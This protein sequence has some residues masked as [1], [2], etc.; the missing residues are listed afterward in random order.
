MSER[1]RV[2][3]IL[4][5]CWI[6][7]GCAPKPNTEAVLIGHIAPSTGPERGAGEHARQAIM[8]ALEEAIAQGADDA[9]RIAAIHAI[10][11]GDKEGG[12][13]AVRL[14]TINRVVA[15][16]ANGELPLT[17]AVAAVAQS[18]GEPILTEEGLPARSAGT[19]VFHLGL[20]P[21]FQAQIMARHAV[22]ELKASKVA[23][24]I[25]DEG[26]RPPAE[27]ALSRELAALFVGE[28]RKEGASPVGEWVYKTGEELKDLVSSH[29][30]DIGNAPLLIAGPLEDIFVVDDLEVPPESAILLAGTENA[31]G[32]LESRPLR[33]V[34]YKASAYAPDN[35]SERGKK[36]AAKYESRFHAGPDVHA[37]LAYD[38]A[39]LLV[40]SIRAAG[41]GDG[42]KL[43]EALAGV[44]DFESV[45]GPLSFDAGHYAVRPGFVLRLERRRT[46][47]VKQYNPPGD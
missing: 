31:S 18:Y 36:F 19:S 9:R 29:K 23:I 26:Q 22:H 45:T 40:E 5:A 32:R 27:K 47:T 25:S 21:Q 30:S 38:G 44:K 11:P 33:H 12:A 35:L 14:I 15:L 3:A 2:T 37:A 4:V 46:T 17:E 39:R 28:L 8:L 42:A 13:A 41:T 6:A 43:R 7:A 20:R 24:L 34:I 16:L 1:G 10:V